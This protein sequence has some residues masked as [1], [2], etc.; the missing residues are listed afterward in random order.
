MLLHVKAERGRVRKLSTRTE[1]AV[2]SW[3]K[4]PVSDEIS[5]SA[6]LLQYEGAERIRTVGVF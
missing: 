5:V 2:A 4:V 3:K 1:V 6:G